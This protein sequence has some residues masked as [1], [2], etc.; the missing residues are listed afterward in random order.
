M[1]SPGDTN[2]NVN[3]FLYLT[4]LKLLGLHRKEK[5]SSI[6]DFF[7]LYC[8]RRNNYGL[9]SISTRTCHGMS[10]CVMKHF[11]IFFHE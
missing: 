4:E 3:I 8:T 2:N 5:N 7:S 10:F 11:P 1:V 9:M 6:T